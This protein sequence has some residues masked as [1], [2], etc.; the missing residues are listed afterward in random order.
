[1]FRANKF[2]NLIRYPSLFNQNQFTLNKQIN[3]FILYSKKNF[4]K[5]SNVLNVGNS[6]KDYYSNISIFV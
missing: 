6:K 4:F 1:M 3:Q 5:K 2:T